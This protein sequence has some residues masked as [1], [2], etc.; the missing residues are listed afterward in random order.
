MSKLVIHGATLKCDQGTS[1][2]TLTVLATE[3]TSAGDQP[4]ATVDDHTA[5]VNIASFG[6]CQTQS[7]P[8]VAAAT[9]AAQGVLTPQPCTPVTSSA[10]SP[11]SSIITINGKK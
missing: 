6:M 1:T 4:A 3:G 5:N 11:G 7:N 10:W 8:Q 9:T 2:A